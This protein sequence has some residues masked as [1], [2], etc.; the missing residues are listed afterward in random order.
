MKQEL[1]NFIDIITEKSDCML[2]IPACRVEALSVLPVDIVRR[3]FLLL[4]FL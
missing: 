1:V 2:L 3:V 4:L